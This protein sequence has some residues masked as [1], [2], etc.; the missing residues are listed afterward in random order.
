[1]TEAQRL[2][3]LLGLRS[4]SL[5]IEVAAQPRRAL[6]A[7]LRL[8]LHATVLRVHQV[9]GGAISRRDELVAAAF[10]RVAQGGFEGLRLRQVAED[11]GIDHSTLYH[12]IVTKQ[13]LIE[14]V[15]D[16]TIGQFRATSP[17]AADP[18]TGLH[19]HLQALAH[20]M[21]ERPELFTVA[22]E[23][24]LRARRDPAV[25]RMMDR[26]E[27]G[28]R[29]A[30]ATLLADSRS[31]VAMHPE[32]AVEVVIAA[33]KG[34]RLVPQRAT[35]VFAQLEALMAGGRPGDNDTHGADSAGLPE[36]RS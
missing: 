33:I 10:Q 8:R 27:S 13:A 23:L 36:N 29:R 1:L 18:A 24:D 32:V 16:F 5:E 20:L 35:A 7:R 9:V 28:W 11:I 31:T 14:A 2:D 22:A 3:V 12:H 25:A 30:L 6:H 17:I 15:A 19:A 34:V 4:R 26:Y 21:L